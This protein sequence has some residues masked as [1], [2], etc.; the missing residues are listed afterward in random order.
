MPTPVQPNAL[1]SGSTSL[2]GG[3]SLNNRDF[4]QFGMSV[5]SLNSQDLPPIKPRRVM[6]EGAHGQFVFEEHY[7]A[8][9]LVMAGQIMANTV[10]DLKTNIEAAKTFLNTFRKDT[11]RRLKL[12]DPLM[13]DRFFYCHF[14]GEAIFGSASPRVGG[15]IADYAIRLLAQPPFALA[16]SLSED[17]YAA[18][19]GTFRSIAT[20]TFD[21]DPRLVI[22]G[23]ATNPKVVFGDSIFICPFDLTTDFTDVFGATVAGTFSGTAAQKAG[24]FSPSDLGLGHAFLANGAYQ[25]SWAV[26]GNKSAGTWF[27]IVEPQ[28]DSTEAGTKTILEHRY[29]ADNRVVLYYVNG[30]GVDQF[31]RRFVFVKYVAGAGSYVASAHQNFVSGNA[32]KIGISYDATGGMKIYVDGILVEQNGVV[33]AMA[34]NPATLTLHAN[35]SNFSA[36]MKVHTLAGW[37]S[38]LTDNEH[39]LIASDPEENIKN[40]NQVLLWTGTLADGDWLEF[41]RTDDRYTGKRMDVSTGV[42]TTGVF[43]DD[44][45]II[46][47]LAAENTAI[48]HPTAIDNFYVQWRNR[49]L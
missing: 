34:G 45:Y 5:L 10:T 2:T 14:D 25:L 22:E 8:K 23:P 13:T 39:A 43:P 19:A 36:N 42:L 7:D 17:R 48:Y 37:S 20:G 24:L 3:G 18:P 46:P 6:R 30:S 28:F 27:V 15:T 26:T 44:G 31:D 49:Y 32:I 41:D 16:A 4:Y 11:P 38:Q 40:R 29:D 47:V 12:I 35:G 1:K 33:G 9:P 21:S